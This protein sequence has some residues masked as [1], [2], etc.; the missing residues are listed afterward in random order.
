MPDLVPLN[1]PKVE[2]VIMVRGFMPEPS[3]W[4]PMSQPNKDL[5][6]VTKQVKELT[7]FWL[8]RG[9][10]EFDI[11]SRTVSEWKRWE[12]QS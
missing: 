3:E 8:K 7:E 2:H 10:Y 12:I 5:E 11:A 9:S 6:A 4:K 1:V